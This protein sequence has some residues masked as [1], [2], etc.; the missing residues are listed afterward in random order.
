MLSQVL[1]NK[2]QVTLIQYTNTNTNTLIKQANLRGL[3][4]H[5]TLTPFIS[6]PQLVFG[7]IEVY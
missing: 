2:S 3:K 6:I 5:Y 7:K 4:S 1:D